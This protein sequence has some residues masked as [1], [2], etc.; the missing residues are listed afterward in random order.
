MQKGTHLIN[1]LKHVQEHME[2]RLVQFQNDSRLRET[3]IKGQY[4]VIVAVLDCQSQSDN[5]R[6]L[7]RCGAVEYDHLYHQTREETIL[8]W[9][10]RSQ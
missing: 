2:L 1:G 4:S 8:S 5:H 7:S 3:I 6:I 10:T 9:T